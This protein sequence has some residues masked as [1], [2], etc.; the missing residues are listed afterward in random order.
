MMVSFIDQNKEELGVESI[1]DT[2]QSAPPTYYAAN[3]VS[4]RRGSCG[5]KC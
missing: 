4:P 1:C 2:L 5:I 3:P